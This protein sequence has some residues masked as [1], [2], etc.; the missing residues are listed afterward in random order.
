MSK[1]KEYLLKYS[2]G[3]GCSIEVFVKEKR[4]E[5]V[6]L[7]FMGPIA[8]IPS[9]KNSKVPGTNFINPKT[10]AR[11][12]IMDYVYGETRAKLGL[13]FPL[14]FG[15][16][17]VSIIVVCAS[18]KVAFDTDNC[19]ATIRDWLEPPLKKVGK[20]KARGWGVGLVEN[21]RQIKGLAV[22]DKDIGLKLDKSIVVVQR[23]DSTKDKLSEFVNHVFFEASEEISKWVVN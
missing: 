8:H 1:L 16:E 4:L 7:E 5:R 9:L 6:K 14:T 10:R 2:S 3:A 23:F 15:K 19:L 13:K 17:D 22:Y 18:R 11:L 20:G 21:D 12:R